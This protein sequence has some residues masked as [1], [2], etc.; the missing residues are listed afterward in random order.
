MIDDLM[1][2]DFSFVIIN[3]LPEICNHESQIKISNPKSETTYVNELFTCSDRVEWFKV[4]IINDQYPMLSNLGGYH[5]IS[6]PDSWKKHREF[7][8]SKGDRRMAHP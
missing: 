8:P 4:K 2:V 1:I 7:P 6:P 5:S 3:P